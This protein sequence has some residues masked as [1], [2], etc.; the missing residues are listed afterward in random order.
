MRRDG[1]E[2]LRRLA[3]GLL[4]A[5]AILTSA[6]QAPRAGEPEAAGLDR[7]SIAPVGT[8]A[9]PPRAG[10]SLSPTGV[11]PSTPPSMETPAQETATVTSTATKCDEMPAPWH[12]FDE[13]HMTEC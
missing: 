8:W 11:L 5:G 10:A 1:I 2:A 13:P 4:V 12:V 7:P 3:L 6:E 9:V